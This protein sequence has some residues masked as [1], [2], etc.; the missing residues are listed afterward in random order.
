MC[1]LEDVGMQSLADGTT[2]PI[3]PILLATLGNDK[4]KKNL[5]VYGH[6]DV[7]PALKVRTIYSGIWQ[8]P[9]KYIKLKE[10]QN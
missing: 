4:N 5:L 7:Q 8:T 2:L 9:E 1:T 10:Q 3:P 6:L